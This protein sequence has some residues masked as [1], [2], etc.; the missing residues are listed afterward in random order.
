MNNRSTNKHL[1]LPANTTGNDYIV[2]DIHGLF[3]NLMELLDIIG[4]DKTKDRLF[5]VGDIIDRGPYS[6]KMIALLDEPWFYMTLG[7]HEQMMVKS[8]LYSEDSYTQC[9]LSNGGGWSELVI[10]KKLLKYAQTLNE[11]PLLISVD[12]SED[13]TTPRFNVC[14]AELIKYNQYGQRILITN[15]ML[16]KWEI[17]AQQEQ[18]MLW[19]RSMIDN[20]YNV[21]QHCYNS[22]EKKHHHMTDLSHTFVGHTIPQTGKP[23]QLEQHIYLDTG[24]SMGKINHRNSNI[25][26]LTIASIKTK[27][28]HTLHTKSK[29]RSIINFDDIDKF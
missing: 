2:G 27:Q 9:W 28:F 15:S 25:F 1:K 3:Y 22:I 20:H 29:Q 21:A 10:H 11:L 18:Y 17:N 6:E 26:G 4:F 16:D 8:I 5:S 12:E 23:I 7:N 13:N 19:G 14:H 24:A